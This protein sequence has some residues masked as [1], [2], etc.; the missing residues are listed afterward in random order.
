MILHRHSPPAAWNGNKDDVPYVG[1]VSNDR[2]TSIMV[3]GGPAANMS[4][5]W[6]SAL[7]SVPANNE[8][9]DRQ[10]RGQPLRPAVPQTPVAVASLPDATDPL[11]AACPNYETRPVSG[12]VGFDAWRKGE[13]QLHIEGDGAFGSNWGHTQEAL[14]WFCKAV[15]AGNG[16]AAYSIGLILE[17][18]YVVNKRQPSGQVV[19]THISPNRMAGYYWYETAAKLG[20]AQGT[21]AMGWFHVVGPEVLKGSTIEKD[22]PKGVALI[23][24]AA[25]KGDTRAQ[26]ML[27]Y[28]YTPGFQSSIP[29]TKDTATALMWAN[30]AQARLARHR[31]TC[32][33]PATLDR[34]LG[35]PDT[36][37][38]GIRVDI[39]AV[40]SDDEEVCSVDGDP[41]PVGAVDRITRMMAGAAAAP[42]MYEL[43]NMPGADQKFPRRETAE[44]ALAENT[45]KLAPLLDS[46]GSIPGTFPRQPQAPDAA[47]AL[48]PTQRH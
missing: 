28:A 27:A 4:L 13:A 3:A 37:R 9:R 45:M 36:D 21:L 30:K 25:D 17:V 31:S 40:R 46:L 15:A 20:Y 32:T 33:D 5:A 12:P 22:V 42:S 24:T 26:L 11:H 14:A 1:R 47:Q 2:L 39:Q 44:Q 10:L 29:V 43:V 7:N 35:N 38:S 34:I 18:G 16:R 23:A 48:R 6:G 19:T 41:T 8:E